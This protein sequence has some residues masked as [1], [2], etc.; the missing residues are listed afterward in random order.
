[1]LLKGDSDSA[2]VTWTFVALGSD[3]VYIVDAL[4]GSLTFSE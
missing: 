3:R 1:M 4:R 2:V